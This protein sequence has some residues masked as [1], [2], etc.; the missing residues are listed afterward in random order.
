M[1]K[2]RLA[3][4]VKEPA[5]LAD[6]WVQ[7]R[8]GMDGAEVPAKAQLYTARLTLDITPELRQRIKLAAIGGGITVAD[9]LREVLE[10]E[11]PELAERR[12]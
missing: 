1:T 11:Y 10:R 6:T 2:K 3:L 5:R 7:L 9:M 12:S 4:T 8:T